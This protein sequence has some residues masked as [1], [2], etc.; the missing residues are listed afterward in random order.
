[1]FSRYGTDAVTRLGKCLA[2][3]DGISKIYRAAQTGQIRCDRRILKEHERL[4][5]IA[6]QV[7]GDASLWW[8]IAAASGIAWAMQV[9]AGIYIRVPRDPSQVLRIIS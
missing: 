3:H 9:P 2:T 4:D 1:M 8:I 5:I 6:G 7:Y